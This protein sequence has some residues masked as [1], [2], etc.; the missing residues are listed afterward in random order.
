MKHLSVIFFTLTI[1]ILSSCSDGQ[2][3]EQQIKTLIDEK[4][5]Q[6]IE[7]NIS[8]SNGRTDV[9]MYQISQITILNAILNAGDEYINLSQ[10][11]H[12]TTSDDKIQLT[13]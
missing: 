10:V 12:I 8:G 6:T 3:I 5:I 13:F 4:A 11:K 9:K 1:L 2:K 7:V